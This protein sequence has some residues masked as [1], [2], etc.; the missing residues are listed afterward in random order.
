MSKVCKE[1]AINR[2][3]TD[4]FFEAYGTTILLAGVI[5]T[6]VDQRMAGIMGSG[7]YVLSVGE[8]AQVRVL[9]DQDFG[10]ILRIDGKDNLVESG[11]IYN[12]VYVTLDAHVLGVVA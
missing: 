5:G 11:C 3:W 2:G 12:E 6:T 1:S 8:R 9:L 10:S 7:F 4:C